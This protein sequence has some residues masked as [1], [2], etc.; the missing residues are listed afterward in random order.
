MHATEHLQLIVALAL[1]QSGRHAPAR[2]VGGVLLSLLTSSERQHLSRRLVCPAIVDCR[3]T[4]HSRQ[5]LCC[6][7]LFFFFFFFF[8]S[9]SLS[10]PPTHYHS[11]L[12]VLV[13]P[14]LVSGDTDHTYPF[15]PTHLSPSWILSTRPLITACRARLPAMRSPPTAL[16]G[17]FF[18]SCR[19]YSLHPD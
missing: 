2:V 17:S 1:R 9:L 14:C 13:R 16:V 15:H 12:R 6:S 5:P 18:S 3:K 8:F 10:L 4:H 19:N 11:L 7:R